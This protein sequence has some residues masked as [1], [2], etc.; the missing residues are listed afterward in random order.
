MY[1]ASSGSPPHFEIRGAASFCGM[2]IYGPEREKAE[3][4]EDEIG[5]IWKIEHAANNFPVSVHF[6]YGEVPPK[7]VQRVPEPN[8]LPSPLDAN[9]SY[10]VVLERCKGGPQIF[11]LRGPHLSEYAG[12]ANICWGQLN[13][14][15]RQ[16]AA[17]VRVDCKTKHPLPMSDRAM[18]RLEEY[19]KNRIPFY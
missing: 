1:A 2:E 16:M 10:K 4:T 7:F 3:W 19:R 17:T 5:L 13:V 9:V 14:M 6:T 12:D 15:E 8:V 11:S 18:Q